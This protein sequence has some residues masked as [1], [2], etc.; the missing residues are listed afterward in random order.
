MLR[1]VWVV[2]LAAMLGACA[3]GQ[4]S[5]YQSAKPTLQ[6]ST[7]NEIA[8]GTQDQRPYVLSGN[9]S[10]TF[11]GN[12]RSR[13]GVPW[14]IHTKS[15][16]PLADDFSTAIASALVDKGIR[17]TV[18]SIP[19]TDTRDQAIKALTDTGKPRALLVSID[20]WETDQLRNMSVKFELKA[21]VFDSMGKELASNDG[22]ANGL[23]A[24]PMKTASFWTANPH[25]PGSQKATEIA[26]QVLQQL[27]NDP[28]I[29]EA[30]K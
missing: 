7:N 30:L 27:L 25:T 14:G 1:T 16:R 15:G 23:V 9:R 12:M 10:L 11:T 24:N 28:K 20:E 21:A 13:A 22:V 3:A 26:Q 5:D 6:V 4:E 8:L 19:A 2:A 18:V 29:V 17:V